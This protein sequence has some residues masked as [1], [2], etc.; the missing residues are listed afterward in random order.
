M[1]L[2]ILQGDATRF[3]GLTFPRYA[4]MLA[5]IRWPVVAAALVRD[6][7]PVGLALAAVE[8]GH[9][10]LLSLS[11]VPQE[12][13]SGHGTELL[14]FLQEALR[15]KADL[16]WAEYTSTLPQRWGFEG[17]LRHAGWAEPV[18]REVR[19]SGRLGPVVDLAERWPG[20]RGSR[21][22]RLGVT[23]DPWSDDASDEAAIAGLAG[24]PGFHPGL[25]PA[26]YQSRI[27]AAIS[28][29]IRQ[30]GQLVGWLL[31]E[32]LPSPGGPVRLNWPT[33]YVTGSL[34]HTGLLIRAFVHSLHLARTIYGEDAV[35]SLYAALPRVT[36]LV[37]RRTEGTAI[38]SVEILQSVRHLR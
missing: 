26:L 12:R 30:Q 5:D 24:E 36:A 8:E 23:L 37:R 18:T 27:E 10:R 17:V 11:V 3:A 25:A 35:A 22:S 6:S 21:D 38:S 19:V 4:P 2:E 20:L 29:K 34:W 7:E 32:R 31:A 13:G 16:I 28:V 1:R 9:A 33:G 14:A 15:S